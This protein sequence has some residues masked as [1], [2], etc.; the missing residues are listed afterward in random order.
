[1]ILDEF[2]KFDEPTYLHQVIARHKDGKLIRYPDLADA[3]TLKDDAAEWRAH[4]HVP[5]F[6]AQFGLLSSTQDDII[7]VLAMWKELPF[8]NHLEVE[9]YT[10]GV[11]P[12]EL[13]I[14]MASSISRELAWVIDEIK[15]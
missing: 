10:W 13:K 4:F 7:E 1:V 5:I 9:T 2:A 6:L 12:P 15:A 3:L 8:T 14:P 11:L